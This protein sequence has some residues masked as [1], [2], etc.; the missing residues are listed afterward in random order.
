MPVAYVKAEINTV[1]KVVR[2]NFHSFDVSGDKL[3][4]SGELLIA[5]RSIIKG[6]VPRLLGAQEVSKGDNSIV[7]AALMVSSPFAASAMQRN[8]KPEIMNRSYS[9][10]EID[11]A[12]VLL[13]AKV[14]QAAAT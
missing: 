5:S 11:S 10:E 12:R 7:G 4:D 6:D 13:N 9:K 3:L 1:F 8:I 14:D 2:D